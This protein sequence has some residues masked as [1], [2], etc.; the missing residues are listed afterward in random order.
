MAKRKK[1][2]PI[3]KKRPTGKKRSGTPS[4]LN[5][6]VFKLGNVL[7]WHNGMPRDKAFKRAHTVQQCWKALCK[8]KVKMLF[9]KEDGSLREAIGTL[10]HGISEKYDNYE[11]KE[12]PGK[13]KK[14]D[15]DLVLYWDLEKEAFRTFRASRFVGYEV[16][17]NG[18]C[19]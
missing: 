10:C 2:R 6:R 14:T 13:E 12:K 15:Y 17:D 7:N 5:S 16:M 3:G 9:Y 11:F 19:G 1:K 8:G 4:V 18:T